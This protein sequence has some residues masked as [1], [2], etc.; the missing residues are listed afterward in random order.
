MSSIHK[1]IAHRKTLT[2]LCAVREL[3]VDDLRAAD[4]YRDSAAYMMQQCVRYGLP[5]N[6]KPRYDLDT[7]IREVDK[8]FWNH[9]FHL[10]G[11]DSVMDRQAREEMDRNMQ[12]G[13]VPE[14]TLETVRNMFVEL[15]QDADHMFRRG[16]AELFRRLPGQYQRHEAY[17]VAP[18][19]ICRAVVRPR[20][21][22]LSLEING[23][24]SDQLN[25]LDRVMCAIQGRKFQPRAL[26]SAMNAEFIEFG[27]Y[28]DDRIKAVPFK[29]GNL[30][31]HFL[32]SDLLDG[33][34]RTI[35]QHYGET[36][37]RG[38]A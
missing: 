23:Y 3:V 11:I 27:E 26:E 37:A 32:D 36:L 1:T 38:A 6:A 20:F 35:A 14:F 8:I 21:D 12:N 29:N 15:S 2:E 33:I 10:T 31:I 7:Q 24:A 13:Q 25:D 22:G 5:S 17:R 34:N 30:H 9:A 4:K 16:V 28:Q 19:I 18:K